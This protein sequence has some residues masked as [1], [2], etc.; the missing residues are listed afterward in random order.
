MGVQL[1]KKQTKLIP[2]SLKNYDTE[3]KNPQWTKITILLQKD[4]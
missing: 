3:A 4:Q 1:T 2:P